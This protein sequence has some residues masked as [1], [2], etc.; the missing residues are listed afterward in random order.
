MIMLIGQSHG[1]I[2]SNLLSSSLKGYKAVGHH[3]CGL[4]EIV[5]HINTPKYWELGVRNQ[6]SSMESSNIADIPI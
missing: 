6:L 2:I 4:S 5:W 3:L 1:N